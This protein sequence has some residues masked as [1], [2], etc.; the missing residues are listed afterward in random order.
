LIQSKRYFFIIIIFLTCNVP[1]FHAN[2]SN[3]DRVDY[4]LELLQEPLDNE[5]QKEIKGAIMR[6]W[7][8]SRSEEIQQK[9]NNIG[10]L[11]KFRQYQD[12]EDTLSLIINEQNDFMDAY[13]QRAI[14]HYY[15]GEINQARSDLLS[16]LSLEPRHFDALR[17]LAFIYEKQNKQVEAYYTYKELEK[18]LPHDEAVRDK[19]KFLKN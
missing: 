9:M 15:Q 19:L 2:S 4:L 16:V 17:V 5:S 3:S 14:I 10:Q 12:A 18:I 1:I 11:I 8:L 7:K 13:Y 6:I